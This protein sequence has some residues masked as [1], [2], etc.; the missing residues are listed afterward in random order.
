MLTRWPPSE[1]ADALAFHHAV[2]A[3]ASGRPFLV[4]DAADRKNEGELVVAAEFADDAV[5][6]LMACQARGL[7]RVAIT[8]AAARRLRLP[9]MVLC[10]GSRFG[11]AFTI[12]VEART[13]VSTGIS[14]QDRARTIAVLTNPESGADDLVSPGH[15]FPIVARDGGV[16]QRPGHT[17]AAIEVVR[18]ANLTPTAVMCQILDE[19]GASVGPRQTR[20]F[21]QRFGWPLVT[22]QDVIA[23]LDPPLT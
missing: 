13:G 14:A 20:A 15:V 16:F 21:A 9:M 18:A 7:I 6:N 17:E 11:T 3:A 5:I 1:R 23:G 10:N 12:S 19:D 4:L 22:V 8:K 2:A